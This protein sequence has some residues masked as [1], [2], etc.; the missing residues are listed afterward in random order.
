MSKS[1]E[2][3]CADG[4]L[5]DDKKKTCRL[6]LIPEMTNTCDENGDTAAA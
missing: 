1:T 4:L 5:Y 2:Q 6:P 3:Q